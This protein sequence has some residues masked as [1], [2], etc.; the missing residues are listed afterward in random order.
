MTHDH[1]GEPG[2]PPG[3]ARDLVDLFKKL[4]HGN[5]Q[6]VGQLA[7]RTNLSASHISEVLR[8]R[9]APSPRAAATIAQA[10][11][12]TADEAR[13]AWRLA[14]DLAELNR[15]NKQRAATAHEAF[16]A[17]ADPSSTRSTR[18]N[19][20]PPSDVSADGLDG[21]RFQRGPS[22]RARW[23]AA[24]GLSVIVAA[25]IAIALDDPQTTGAQGSLIRGSATCESGRPVIA[26]WIA[27]STGQKD[28][29]Y[30]HLGPATAGATHATGPTVTYSY[31][32]PHGGTYNAHVGCGGT[33][34]HWDSANFSP[35]ISTR[36]AHLRCDD[37]T[38]GLTSTGTCTP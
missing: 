38:T 14:E 26:I 13:R 20:A 18:G 12:A 10:L 5:R 29:G 8:G 17:V 3:P 1:R 27:A 21:S 35:P 22:R 23:I 16:G 28:S 30:A 11:G 32:L 7:G 24:V 9:K 36:V 33:S 19:G 31:L 15:Y 25:L 37:P 34:S 2:L 4:R 6:T